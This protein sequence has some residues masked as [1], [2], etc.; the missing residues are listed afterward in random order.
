M[1]VTGAGVRLSRAAVDL[2]PS[3]IRRFFDLVAGMDDVISLG[4]GEPDFPTPWRICDSVIQSLR[5]ARP[6]TPAIGA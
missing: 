3:G 4:V 5:Q 6:P 1:T 2:R